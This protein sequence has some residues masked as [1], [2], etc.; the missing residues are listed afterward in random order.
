MSL[1]TMVSKVSNN[2]WSWLTDEGIAGLV[3]I[4]RCLVNALIACAEKG[5]AH[6]D[7]KP[8]NILISMY[9]EIKLGDF[10]ESK[11]ISSD[12]P[13]PKSLLFIPPEF[14]NTHRR[15][16]FTEID[17]QKKCK[18]DTWCYVILMGELILGKNPILL[19]MHL[20]KFIK[21]QHLDQ[22]SPWL[23]I[24]SSLSSSI[25]SH[26]MWTILANFFETIFS[27]ENDMIITFKKEIEKVTKDFTGWEVK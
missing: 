17:N 25:D 9:G 22:Y 26:L 1:D 2:E 24:F 14:L 20:T 11:E 18:V 21:S 27:K 13:I 8:A 23:A 16:Y 6:K 7:I 19:L 12:D 5:I 3:H 10:G 4:S 15:P